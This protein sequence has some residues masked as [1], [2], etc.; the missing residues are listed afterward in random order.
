VLA[1]FSGKRL[2]GAAVTLLHSGAETLS[3]QE[4]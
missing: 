4:I 3:R 1:G 2:M